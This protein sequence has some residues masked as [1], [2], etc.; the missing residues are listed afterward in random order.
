MEKHSVSKLIGSPPGYVGHNESGTFT[1]S[2]RHRPYSVV[3]FDEIEKAHPEVFNIL[4]QVLDDGRLTDAKGRVVDFK[5]TI[6][7]MTSNLGSNHIQKMQSIGFTDDSREDNYVNTKKK[8]ME[9]LKDFF[10][11]E[12]LNRLDEIIVFDTLSKEVITDIVT[13]QLSIVEERIAAKEL[14]FKY[15]KKVLS[16]LAEKGFDPQYGARPLKRIIQNE[17]LNVIALEM[18]KQNIKMGDAIALDIKDSAIVIKKVIPSRTM[19]RKTSKKT[20]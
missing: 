11:P 13:S 5:N 9:S 12:F 3:L 10:R 19:K 7:I 18:V 6:I 16:Y 4:L 1:E 14:D 2:I 8:V 15:S 20:S 17:I